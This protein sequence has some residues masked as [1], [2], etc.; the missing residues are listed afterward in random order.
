MYNTIIDILKDYFFN[1]KIVSVF[2]EEEK[3]KFNLILENNNNKTANKEFIKSLQLDLIKP[4]KNKSLQFKNHKLP[5]FNKAILQSFIKK[6]PSML[7]FKNTYHSFLKI[8]PMNDLFSFCKIIINYE[9]KEYLNIS[10]EKYIL[11]LLEQNFLD[12][13]DFNSET[14]LNILFF[15]MNFKKNNEDY[16]RFIKNLLIFLDCHYE[17]AKDDFDIRKQ[18]RDFDF[19]IYERIRQEVKKEDL[20]KFNKFWK[21]ILIEDGKKNLMTISE[22]SYLVFD[23]EYF[24]IMKN[25]KEIT[26]IEYAKNSCYF[27]KDLINSNFN[28]ELDIIIAKDSNTTTK[29]LCEI[30]NKNLNNNILQPMLKDIIKKSLNLYEISNFYKQKKITYRN[31]EKYLIYLKEIRKDIDYWILQNNLIFKSQ[32]E[33]LIKI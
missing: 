24:Y 3:F 18:K 13:K 33:K 5:N 6:A 7:E 27:V 14:F 4:I 15:N 26:N 16:E 25:F 21:D 32:E 29:F 22:S 9:N 1:K 31:E 10:C 23:L 20:Y 19:K 12:K 2:L 8:L 28:N 30:K 17:K 11:F